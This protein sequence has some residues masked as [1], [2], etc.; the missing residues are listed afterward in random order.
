MQY[1]FFGHVTPLMPVFASLMLVPSASLM[2]ISSMA[3]LHSL[4]QDDWNEMQHYFFGCVTSFVLAWAS[5]DANS[6]IDGTIASLSSRGLKTCTI[7]VQYDFLVM[8]HHWSNI[9]I[10]WWWHWHQMTL[11]ST[12]T[13]IKSLNIPKQSSQQDRCN[14]VIHGT[15][16]I[17]WQETCYCHVYAKTIMLH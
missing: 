7:H 11:T 8:Q 1:G 12:S 17:M 6:V 10:M 5:C 3:P 4:F 2:L 14:G 13:G 15:N 9:S 16:S